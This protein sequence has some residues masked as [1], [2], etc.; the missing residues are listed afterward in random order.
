MKKQPQIRFLHDCLL[1]DNEILVIGDL[2]L[3]YNDYEKLYE[4][5]QVKKI[6][7]KLDGIFELLEKEKI[8]VEKIILLGDLKHD[9]GRI[10]NNEWREGIRFLDYLI[11]R[12]D[13]KNIII[14]KG[15]H[16]AILKPITEKRGIV[17]KD[18]F[19]IDGVCF[20]HGDKWFEDCD[21]SKVLVLGHLHP[22]VTLSDKYKREKYKCFLKGK[23]KR[24]AVYVLPSFSYI[25]FGYDLTSDYREKEN[26]EFFIVEDKKLKDFE[27]I[28]YNYKEDKEYNFG[29]LKGL[30]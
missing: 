7:R 16:D 6:I 27:V 15:N 10:S 29:K 2:H 17:L 14:I 19:K 13:K 23:W 24:K 21:S 8:N 25:S 26:K 12:V 3:G 9:F 1:V 11:E 20:L 28:V 30:S 18:H 4:R 22:S 5:D